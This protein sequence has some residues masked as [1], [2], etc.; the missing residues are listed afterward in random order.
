MEAPGGAE[1]SGSCDQV[2]H[3]KREGS[4]ETAQAVGK[5][6][7]VEAG[8]SVPDMCVWK[9][10]EAVSSQSSLEASNRCSAPHPFSKT[11]TSD[12]SLLSPAGCT[13][14]QA[15][16]SLRLLVFGCVSE[17]EVPHLHTE[18]ARWPG[19]YGRDLPPTRTP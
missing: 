2:V 17:A 15:S 12:L 16:E 13:H 19:Q 18:W 8:D 4:G 14:F 11:Q 3:G 7:C 1:G 5:R 9:E 10:G 6:L